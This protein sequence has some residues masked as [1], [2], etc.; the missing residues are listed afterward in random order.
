MSSFGPLLLGTLPS[1]FCRFDGEFRSDRL[2]VL[3]P[4]RSEVQ[5]ELEVR[6]ST[7]GRDANFF[8][9]DQQPVRLSMLARRTYK[10]A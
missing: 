10:D 2:F 8:W 1:V 7:Y 4:G 3:V 5:P 6:V 9:F